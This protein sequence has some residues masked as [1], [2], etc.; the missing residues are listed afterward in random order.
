MNGTPDM[1]TAGLKMI[2]S[3]GVVLA[4][5]LFL[6]YGIRRLTSQRMGA[7]GGK[8]IQVLESHYMG[9]KK[10]ISLVRVP[11]KVLVLGISGDRIN[12]LDTLDEDIVQ[13]EAPPGASTSFGPILSDRLKKIGNGFKRKE[14]L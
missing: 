1:I 14:D 5:I 13:Q 10:T 7:A 12:L 4:M 9:V 6:L 2:A 8:R 11:G 3:L